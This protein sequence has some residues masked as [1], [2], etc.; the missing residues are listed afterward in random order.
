[1]VQNCEIHTKSQDFKAFWRI[2]SIYLVI[3]V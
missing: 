1:M 3:Y 2:L